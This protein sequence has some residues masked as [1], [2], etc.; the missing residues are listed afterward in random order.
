MPAKFHLIRYGR[1]DFGEIPVNLIEIP[2]H[3]DAPEF[4]TTQRYSLHTEYSYGPRKFEKEIYTK[5][6]S[7]K[8]NTLF[9]IPQLW[10]SDDWAK[11]FFVFIENFIQNKSAPEIIEI[12]PPFRDY[13]SNISFFLKRYSIFENELTNYF[14]DTKIFIENRK[15]NQ[16]HKKFLVENTQDIIKLIEGIA[17]G[18]FKLQLVLDIPTFISSIK[19]IDFKNFPLYYEPLKEHLSLI[20][21]IHIWGRERIPHMGNLD[22]LFNGDRDIKNDSLKFLGKFFDDGIPRYIVPEVNGTKQAV[23]NEILND[24]NNHFELI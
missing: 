7:L 21:G 9:G 13:C 11:E 10:F 2:A 15:G 24:L 22:S 8:E 19:N 14:P 17:D 6:K 3:F 23:F 16:A 5:L 1:Y 18:G 20:G 12:H 4:Q